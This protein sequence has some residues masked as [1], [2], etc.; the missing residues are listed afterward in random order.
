ME[1]KHVHFH[2]EN[3]YG[4]KYDIHDNPNAVFNF[5][6]SKAKDE[7]KDKCD[8]QQG[9]EDNSKLVDLLT[10]I[11]FGDSEKVKSYLKQIQ[12]CKP[13]QVVAVT[14]RYLQERA[15]S[16]ASCHTPLWTI[17]HDNGLYNPSLSNWNSQ[18]NS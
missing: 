18:L 9:V 10:P 14:R 1:E 8:N 13:T 7:S 11:F 12:G 3:I 6:G 5:G 4:D 16:D 15:I 2:Q 17:L